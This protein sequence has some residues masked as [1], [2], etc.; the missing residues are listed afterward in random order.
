MPSA[1]YELFETGYCIPVTVDRILIKSEYF[2]FI[3]NMLKCPLEF[4]SKYEMVYPE[5]SQLAREYLSV[6][7]SSAACERIFSI[8]GHIFALR[9]EDFVMDYF[10][11]LIFSN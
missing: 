2:D 4:W 11:T 3:D 6:Q 1:I 8:A 7:A 5:I 9:E 10:R